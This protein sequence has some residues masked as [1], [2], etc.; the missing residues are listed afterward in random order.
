MVVFQ[1]V[2]VYYK[3]SDPSDSP[4]SRDNM[5]SMVRSYDSNTCCSSRLRNDW[6]NGKMRD[7]RYIMMYIIKRLVHSKIMYSSKAKRVGSDRIAMAA[8]SEYS[9]HTQKHKHILPA[10]S[11]HQVFAPRSNHPTAWDLDNSALHLGP[12]SNTIGLRS[13]WHLRAILHS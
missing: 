11:I 2:C 13:N 9:F 5:A 10:H 6:S 4:R 7:K 8:R 12:C 3:G 1:R